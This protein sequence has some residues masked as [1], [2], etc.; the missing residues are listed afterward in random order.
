VVRVLIG[1]SHGTPSWPGSHDQPRVLVEGSGG[2]WHA[3]DEGRA[4]GLQ[5]LTC[6]GPAASSC[7]AVAGE[8]CALAVGA[9]AIVVSRPRDEEIC[10][11]LLESHALVHP[12][13]PVCLE[14]S[15]HHDVNH[16]LTTTTCLVANASGVVAF[17]ERLARRRGSDPG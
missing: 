2:R 11:G 6:P 15:P 16:R 10:R 14:P 1:T 9:D 13:V 3:E 8:P 12:G 4:A 5:V 17:V 7:P